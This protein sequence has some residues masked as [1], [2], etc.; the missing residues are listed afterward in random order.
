MRRMQMSAS[1]GGECAIHSALEKKCDSV[2]ATWVTSVT[3]TV[4]GMALIFC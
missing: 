3:A 1:G 2:A 4:E